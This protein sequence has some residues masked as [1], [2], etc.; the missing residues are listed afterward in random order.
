[1]QKVKWELVNLGEVKMAIDGF[2]IKII[3]QDMEIDTLADKILFFSSA[4][5]KTPIIDQS[6]IH[7]SNDQRYMLI[8]GELGFSYVFDS[9]TNSF[10]LYKSAIFYNGENSGSENAICG[11]ETC[12]IHA[13]NHI[14]YI[15]FPFIEYSKFNTAVEKY[16]KER[17]NQV[18]HLKN[19]RF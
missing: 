17:G 18:T 16:L 15:Q 14:Y 6:K 13:N 12:H 2:G 7:Y 3:N 1:M 5:N 9:K 8:F 19:L 10:S 4:G 11:N